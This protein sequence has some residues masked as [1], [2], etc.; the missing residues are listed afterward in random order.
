L[1]CTL[2]FILALSGASAWAEGTLDTGT[3]VGTTDTV[4][5]PGTPLQEPDATPTGD[6]SSSPDPGGGGTVSGL[7]GGG[8]T[9]GGS[10]SDLA[11]AIASGLPP[12][13]HQTVN[14]DQLLQ[15]RTACEQAAANDSDRMNCF[16]G[17]LDALNQGPAGAALVGASSGS[18]AGNANAALTQQNQKIQQGLAAGQAAL[19]QAGANGGG[20]ASEIA[21]IQSE[22]SALNQATRDSMTAGFQEFKQA[23][24][25]GD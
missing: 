18:S 4:A 15:Q 9:G 2:I 8:T 10:S 21:P 24:G 3:D 14:Y 13:S 6:V 20:I 12:V 5:P 11:S 23:V 19:N 16:Y 7:S 1:F 22:A 25:L 17:Y